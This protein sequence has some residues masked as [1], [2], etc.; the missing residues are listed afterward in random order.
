LDNLT[1]TLVGLAAARAGLDRTS[2]LATATCVLAANIPD[3]DIVA[4]AGGPSFYLEHHRGVTHSVVGTLALGLLLPLMMVGGERVWARLRGREPRA[5]LKGLLLCSLLLAASHPLLDW[6]NSYGVKPLL[7]WDGTW[8]YGDL[9]FILDPYLWLTLGGTVFLASARSKWRAGVWGAL[10]AA[11]SLALLLLPARAGLSVPVAGY[12]VWFA[13]LGLVV[14]ARVYG[15]GASV[16]RGLCAAALALVVAYWGGLAVFQRRAFEAARVAAENLAA[17]AGERVQRVAAMPTLAD[18]T[19]WLCAAETDAATFRY[20]LDLGAAPSTEN[21]R[22]VVRV[23]KPSGAERELIESAERDE[24]V[25]VLLDFARFPVARL[26][27]NC[28][29][30]LVAQFADLRFTAP[31][32]RGRG[33][34]FSVEAPVSVGR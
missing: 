2:A 8:F 31:G 16:G 1:H 14:W 24:R 18:P 32:E 7:P 9:V 5:K 4:L 12:A 21:L 3:A 20:Q 10:A 27:R 28:A 29:G 34:S 17:P 33:G 6:T 26:G 25:A 15:P 30:E 23:E 11:L 22:K 19:V 13:G